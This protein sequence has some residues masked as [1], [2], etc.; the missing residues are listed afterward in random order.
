MSPVDLTI[1]IVTWNGRDL[2]RQCL[3][4]IALASAGLQVETL[5]VDNG[6]T[7]HSAEMVAAE[8][9]PVRL[10]RNTSNV[11]FAR[12]N[13]QAAALSRGRYLFF[14]NSDALVRPDCLRQ[15]VDFLEANPSVGMVGPRLLEP[16]GRPQRS[17]RGRPTVAA[18]LHRLTLLKWTGFFRGPYERYRR[19]AFNPDQVREVDTVLGAA[20][21]VPRDVFFE[22]GGWDDQFPFGLEDFDLSVRIA[23]SRPVVFFPGAEVVHFGRMSSRRNPGY[24]FVGVECGYARYVRKH[25]L[26]PAGLACYKLLVTLNLPF[27]VTAEAVRELWRRGRRGTACLDQPHSELAPLWHFATRGLGLFW[28]S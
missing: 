12:A 1:I 3:E 10:I 18:L 26:G 23:R 27:A 5:V 28:R 16:D 17:Y 11:G 14:L 7:D 13:N 15:L 25:L 19:D 4:A 6:S 2:L 21:C 24:A 22:H 8:F 20:V 9:P